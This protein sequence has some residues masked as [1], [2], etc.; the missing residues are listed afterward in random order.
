[1]RFLTSTL[2]KINIAAVGRMV[3]AGGMLFVLATAVSAQ[4][5]ETKLDPPGEELKT[6][7]QQFEAAFNK[8]DAAAI[9]Q[10]WQESGV[11]R[12]SSVDATL[13]GRDAILKAY[14]QLFKADPEIQLSLTLNSFRVVSPP[15]VSV[16]C[17][18]QVVH[19]DKSVSYSRLSALLFKQ[20]NQWLVSEV[21]EM[22]IPVS[23]TTPG[24]MLHELAWLVGTW[25]DATDKLQV[26][27]HVFW[28]PGGNY[29]VRDYQIATKQGLGH[30]GMQIICW[31][32]EKKEIRC[33]QFEADGSF[34]EG[35][36]QPADSGSWRCPMVVKLPDGR[37]ASFTQVI[38]PV[39]ENEISLS[40]VDMEVD[41]QALP[42]S[43]PDKLVRQ[44]N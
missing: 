17:S 33:W 7:F 30:W 27:N 28:G 21:D 43:G 32:N 22:D 42:G 4:Q 16:K 23:V 6:F 37:R 15:V 3:L 20:G 35:T 24:S 36:Y 1:M 25:S 8:H 34:G 14:Q 5:A 9:A 2:Q 44:S 31:D 13:E 40:L 38:R 39:S 19:T 29:L 26:T 41:G 11:H 12:Q 10:L 18:T